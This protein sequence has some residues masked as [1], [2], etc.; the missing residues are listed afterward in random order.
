RISGEL[1][2]RLSQLYWINTLGAVAGTLLAGFALLASF[3]LRFTVGFAVVLNLAAGAIALRAA[4]GFAPAATAQGSVV[5]TKP[6]SPNPQSSL[7]DSH[8]VGSRFLLFLFAVTGFT[9]FANEI[10]WTRMLAIVIG[11]STYAFTVMLAAVLAGTVIG[12]AFFHR[13]L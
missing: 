6:G 9:A 11:S 8:H 13:F 7:A 2:Q 10:A 5:R 3:G 1:G 4:K 12:S